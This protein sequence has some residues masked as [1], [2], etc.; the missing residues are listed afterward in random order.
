M[1][2]KLGLSMQCG[3]SSRRSNAMSYGSNV[4]TDE[5]NLSIGVSLQEVHYLEDFRIHVNLQDNVR[6]MTGIDYIMNDSCF[7]W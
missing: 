2:M 5:V 6:D 7:D 3:I 1:A 4:Y